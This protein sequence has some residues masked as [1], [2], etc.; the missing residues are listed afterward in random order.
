MNWVAYNQW[1]SAEYAQVNGVYPRF[2]Q[3]ALST[4]TSKP[5][6]ILLLQISHYKR[7]FRKE[8]TSPWTPCRVFSM[9]GWTKE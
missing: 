9:C 3:S 1:Y 8:T 4:P 7:L 6:L 2:F 5:P